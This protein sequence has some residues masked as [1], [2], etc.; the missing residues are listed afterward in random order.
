M[1]LSKVTATSCNVQNG[2][3]V[4][5]N[6]YRIQC[7]QTLAL[8]N[9]IGEVTSKEFKDSYFKDQ[10]AYEINH[11]KLLYAFSPPFTSTAKISPETI[12]EAI[13]LRL[14]ESDYCDG[15]LN[16]TFIRIRR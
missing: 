12:C 3:K 1:A 6:S 14:G 9:A 5:T 2:G 15:E 4:R 10:F 13:E 7:N 16:I 11:P 8:Y